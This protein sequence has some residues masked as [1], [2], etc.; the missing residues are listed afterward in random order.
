MTIGFYTKW[1]IG[2]ILLL[3]IIAGACY[4]WYQHDT[5]P[6]KQ[7]AA[8][9]AEVAREWEATQ[10]ADTSKVEQAADVSAESKMPTADKLVNPITGAAPETDTRT[11]NPQDVPM[12]TEE[13]EKV[14]PHDFL[15]YPKVP[16]D[17]P[18]NPP[19][20]IR[21]PDMI[22]VPAHAAGPL[23][24]LDMVL[25]KLWVQGHKNITGASTAYGKIYPHYRDV[26]YVKYEDV[27]FPNGTVKRK[28]RRVLSGP[29]LEYGSR[30]IMTGKVP[31]H[32]KIVEF[33][34]AGIDP[35]TF[36]KE[37]SK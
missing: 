22:G 31:A 29:D 4:L 12:S 18:L 23:E 10:K 1:I 13:T 6:Y 26:I 28:I 27:T 11:K 21:N 33:D 30:D 3:I 20:W 19:I 36:L 14:S 37:D 9:T 24:L 25:V 16:D 34:D 7:E 32:I 8:E 5:A 35:Y 15:P 17:Y 2:G